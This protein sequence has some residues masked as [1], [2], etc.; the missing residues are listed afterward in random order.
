MNVRCQA[1]PADRINEARKPAGAS[2][3]SDQR[4]AQTRQYSLSSSRVRQLSIAD[5]NSNLTSLRDRE[6]R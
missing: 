4:G 3:R 2:G 6:C 5:I 1:H